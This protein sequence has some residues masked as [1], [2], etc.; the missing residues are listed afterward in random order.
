[1]ISIIDRCE[2]K[3]FITDNQYKEL[4]QSIK[5]KIEKDLYYQETIYNLYFDNDNYD[6]INKSLDKPNYKEKIRLRSY[7]IV[8]D[9]TTVFLEI[10]KKFNSHTNKRR[11]I[12]TYEDFIDYYEHRLLPKFNRQI[13]KELDYCFN[14][15][16]LKPKIKV[17]YD[18][19]SYYLKNN[20]NFRITFDNNIRY[21]FD[22]LNFKEFNNEELLFNQ[23]YI[24]E[25]KTFDSIPM[26]LTKVLTTLKIY[27]TSY[28]KVGKI[29]EKERYN[30]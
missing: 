5:D 24:M 15:Y 8:N 11:I 28:S 13:V 9:N 25:I 4:M 30:V 22:N 27:P 26:W 1:M 10:K 14:K 12:I 3:Y 16:N 7:E 20:K 23:G 29:C 21:S 2:Q 17:R 6:V 18:R 19:L